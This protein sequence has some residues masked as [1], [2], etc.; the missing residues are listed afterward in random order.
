MKAITGYVLE[1]CLIK[2]L[3]FI[4]LLSQATND[5]WNSS[6]PGNFIDKFGSPTIKCPT[7]ENILIEEEYSPH[8]IVAP[9]PR[10]NRIFKNIQKIA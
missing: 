4:F 5:S 9:H 10:Y 8:Q 7:G 3:L 2:L 6:F 1:I